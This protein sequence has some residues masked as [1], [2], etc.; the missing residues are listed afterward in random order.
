MTFSIYA[1]VQIHKLAPVISTTSSLELLVELLS[2]HKSAIPLLYDYFKR[3]FSNEPLLL[4]SLQQDAE[5][6]FH[7]DQPG[8]V[9]VDLQPEHMQC[10]FINHEG[11]NI[12]KVVIGRDGQSFQPPQ[13]NTPT[14]QPTNSPTEGALAPGMTS[15]IIA[16]VAVF[17]LLI[18]VGVIAFT[19][20]T[21]KKREHSQATNPL[22]DEED[23]AQ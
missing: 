8:F 16:A 17:L 3:R 18:G 22:L 23:L 7:S 4:T 21:C 9:L 15:F 6:L 5:Q 11:Q 20:I 2:N 1:L 12:Y 13:S 19:I 14:L 10:T